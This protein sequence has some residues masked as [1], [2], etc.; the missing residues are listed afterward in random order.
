M[1]TTA[2]RTHQLPHL[3]EVSDSDPQPTTGKLSGRQRPSGDPA[4]HRPVTDAHQLAGDLNRHIRGSNTADGQSG[5]I[6]FR[7]GPSVQPCRDSGESSRGGRRLGVSKPDHFRSAGTAAT[8]GFE[9]GA[10]K[11]RRSVNSWARPHQRCQGRPMTRCILLRGRS[12]APAQTPT[13]DDSRGV[14]PGSFPDAA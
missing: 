4:A 9:A 10:L 3:F 14:E 5:Q 7:H 8:M 13:A 2:V 12:C 6:Q 11:H 1:R